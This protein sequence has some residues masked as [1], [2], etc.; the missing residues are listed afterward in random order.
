MERAR[1]F[2]YGFALIELLMVI[3]VLGILTGILFA[4][5]SSSH[6]K[7]NETAIKSELAV[8]QTQAVRYYGIGNT[9]GVPNSGTDASCTQSGT[10]F[11]DAT[12]D[13]DNPI[14][15]AISNV[16]AAVEGGESGVICRSED[17]SFLVAAKL[18]DGIYWCIDSNGA[19]R[20]IPAHSVSDTSIMKCPP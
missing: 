9:Y 11:N 1:Y 7:G 3:A 15:M 4:S 17:T 6:G 19:A 20:Q 16:R 5:L 12:T 2:S 10:M 8:I 14:S 13:I 18:S